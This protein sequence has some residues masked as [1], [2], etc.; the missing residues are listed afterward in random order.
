MTPEMIG[1]DSEKSGVL[2]M[3][4]SFSGHRP[5][6]GI[7]LQS[8]ILLCA[9]RCQGWWARRKLASYRRQASHLCCKS[10]G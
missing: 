9:A 2:R 4:P 10:R 8:L 1:A 6:R 7:S 5:L 3:R